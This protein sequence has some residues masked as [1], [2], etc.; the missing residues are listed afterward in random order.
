MIYELP[1][2]KEMATV[3]LREVRN[4]APE[5]AEA[6]RLLRFLSYFRPIYDNEIPR[7]SLLREFLGGSA[8]EL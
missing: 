3:V 8:F 1:A 2:I 4:D 5:A 7:T 6:N